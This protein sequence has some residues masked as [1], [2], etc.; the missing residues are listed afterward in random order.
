MQ[1]L[2]RN[3][4]FALHI[5]GKT[6][7]LTAAAILTLALGIGA[8]SAIFTVTN[9]L[10]LKPFPYRDPGQLVS[11]EAR[12]KTQD[13]GLNL[14]RYEMLRDHSRS[15]DGMAVWANDQLN[16]SGNGDPMQIA[17]ARVSPNFFSLLGVQ[18]ELGRDFT[19]EEGRPEGKPVVLLSDALWRT[20]YHADPAIVGQVIKLDS[21]AATVIG[22]LPGDVQFPFVGKAEIWTSHYFEFSL[23]PT[24]RLRQGV[25]YLNLVV[26]LRA[27]VTLQQANTELAVLNDQYRLQYATMPDADPSVELKAQPLRD[28]VMGDLRGKVL[29]LMAA[30][31][32]VL[33]IACGNVASLLL[34]RAM[35]RRR[36]VAVRAA[37]GANRGAIVGQL[38]TESL[39]LALIA[40]VFGIALGW[41]A[42]RA[43]AVFGGAQLPRGVP[44]AVDLRVLLF[45]LGVSLFAGLLFGMAPALQLAAVD[46]NNTLR[47]EGRGASSSM[48]RVK[49]R[50]ALVVGQIGL[51]LLLLIGAGLLVRSFV[52]L[53]AVDPGF[54]A[55]NALTLN[56][57]LS[58]LK[59]N[60][61]AQQLAF[62]DEVL[63]RLGGLPGVRS[64][65]ISAAQPLRTVRVTPVLAQGQPDRPLAQRPFVD[66][67]AISPGWFDTMRVPLRAGRTFNAG[68]QAQ[69][70]PV[71]IVNESFARQYW[72]NAH[73]IDQHVTVGRRPIPALV[74]GVAADVKN[75]GLQQE[76]QPQ[77]YLPFSQL[78]WSSM[79]LILR[80]D[81]PPQSMIGA[82]RKQI[83]AVDPDQPL[84]DV[85]SVDELIDSARAQPRFLLLLVG[86]FAG[87]ALVL[88]VIGI[89]GVL[90]FSVAQRRQEFGIRM[91]MGADREAI[92][93]VVLRHGFLLA[94][95][96]VSLGAGAGLF[97][98]KLMAGMLYKTAGRD[99]VTFI[100]APVL[101]LAVATLASYL[102]ARRATRVNPIDALR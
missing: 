69:S 84:T 31:G 43:L 72:P 77:L 28:L 25:G 21:N 57:S 80:T 53:L 3:L 58:T 49:A 101:L 34:S 82:V 42:T 51:S 36:E 48:A 102:P 87:L 97:L 33:L 78:P 96:G 86:A 41:G 59:Y 9:A 38:L 4:R 67:E 79:N 81:A 98:A 65:A 27:G 6:P 24:E 100:A 26:R 40:A 75:R 55:H 60:T 7:A 93:A 35:A 85:Q 47:E 1:N 62:F 95:I 61:P 83:A 37:L 56:L 71:V 39:L 14:V 2:L 5:M 99:P 70:A 18:P 52:R 63:R 29:M 12:D 10:L 46:M 17:V 16:L 88:A 76:T 32:V 22:V 54:E 91:A 11:V 94:L 44:V 74:V 89:Y 90:S 92:L 66:I 8:N 45:T 15:F 64:A 73:P 19:P 30:V 20:R 50:D 68:D 13:R 23:M